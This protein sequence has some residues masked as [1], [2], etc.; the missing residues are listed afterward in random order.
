M[1][2]RLVASLL[3]VCVTVTVWCPQSVSAVHACTSD[4]DSAKCE[5]PHQ[6]G[7]IDCSD[8]SLTEVPDQ[9]PSTAGYLDLSFNAISTLRTNQ[10]ARGNFTRMWGLQL[11]NNQIA[12]VEDGA[13]NNIGDLNHLRLD[14]NQMTVVT[15][16]MFQG[17]GTVTHLSMDYNQIHT[18]EEGAFAVFEKLYVLSIQGN[19]LATLTATMFQGVTLPEY[20]SQFNFRYNRIDTIQSGALASLRS[21][22]ELHLTGN[23]LQTVEE[24]SLD[25][26]NNL[27]S[28]YIS[29]NPLQTIKENSLKDL[30]KVRSLSIQFTNMTKL[31]ANAFAGMESLESLDLQH[32]KIDDVA[33]N[34]LQAVPTLK[35][36]TLRYNNLTAVK[37]GVFQNAPHL[38]QLDLSHNPISQVERNSFRALPTLSTLHLDHTQLSAIDPEA[39]VGGDFGSVYIDL[40][41]N[42]MTTMPVPVCREL[43][44]LG[45]VDL[46]G[47]PFSCDCRMTELLS[48]CR[49]L[50]TGLNSQVQ[51]HGPQPLAGRPMK[52]VTADLLVCSPPSITE[53]HNMAKTTVGDVFA[54]PCGSTG[55]PQPI[56]E[57]T[58]PSSMKLRQGEQ[59]ERFS[60]GTDGTLTINTVV[61]ADG[62][63]YKCTAMNTEGSELAISRLEVSMSGD[64]PSAPEGNSTAIHLPEEPSNPIQLALVVTLCVILGVLLVLQTV[65]VWLWRERRRC[66]S[67]KART[68][69]VDR[70]GLIPL[71]D[72]NQLEDGRLVY[73]DTNGD[74]AYTPRGKDSAA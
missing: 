17:L 2:P 40:S 53:A 59:S 37:S 10:F 7:T 66:R 1:N 62:G 46:H 30:K 54:L 32:N 21:L 3:M 18:I 67:Q 42:K 50:V 52:D 43:L 25:G 27:E 24:G 26:L 14:N 22:E 34:T 68:N 47:N 8:K 61:A 23:K 64:S 5:C 71:A 70:R 15:A 35:V 44:N 31:E 36:L 63:S 58:L 60:V 20:G 73:T 69:D 56:V 51:C 38:Q 13:F 16:G 4:G 48:G 55:S 19:Q 41:Y 11:G 33:P 39:F 28:L 29:E 49:R 74:I 57:W 9:V 65:Y 12:S 6:F 45:Q 72:A